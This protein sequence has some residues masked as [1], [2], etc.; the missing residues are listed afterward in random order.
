MH[1]VFIY[2]LFRGTLRSLKQ[3]SLQL[4]NSGL[5]NMWK[6]TIMACTIVACT[7]VACIIVA[8]SIVACTVPAFACRHR[9]INLRLRV[10][11]LR[12][13]AGSA[14]KRSRNDTNRQ[15][16]WLICVCVSLCRSKYLKKLS[17]SLSGSHNSAKL[18]YVLLIPNGAATSA[19]KCCCC[20]SSVMRHQLF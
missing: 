7:A 9:T 2:G 16:V 8:C 20:C 15:E 1:P 4:V 17:T 10:F 13:E 19:P 5:D 11:G 6:E 12:F 14:R 18:K 3:C